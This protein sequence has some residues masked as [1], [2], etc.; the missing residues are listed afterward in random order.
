MEVAR[1]L[2]FLCFVLCHWF[3]N[4]QAPEGIRESEG[5]PS[6]QNGQGIEFFF[7][8]DGDST[9]VL[10]NVIVLGNLPRGLSVRSGDIVISSSPDNTIIFHED[11]S[12]T[13]DDRKMEDVS[14][15]YIAIRM[16]CY[17]LLQDLDPD[18]EE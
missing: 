9:E 11:G 14:G 18:P 17:E 8:P 5:V 15:A 2:L 7:R 3:S 4:A 13:W 1:G 16:F 10:R 6:I 12:L